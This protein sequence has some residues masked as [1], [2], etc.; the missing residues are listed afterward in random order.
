MINLEITN[1]IYYSDAYTDADVGG[2]AEQ[3]K[4]LKG[5]SDEEARDPSARE[6]GGG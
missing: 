1:G 3:N 5:Q 6:V 2:E 4:R